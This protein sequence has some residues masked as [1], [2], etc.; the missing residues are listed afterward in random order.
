MASAEELHDQVARWLRARG[1]RYT[2]GRRQLVAALAGLGRPATIGEVLAADPDLPQSSAYRNL[3]TLEE[4][5]VV[6]RVSGADERARFEL[7]EALTGHHHHLVCTSCGEVTDVTIPAGVE[8]LLDRA[9]AA[10][11]EGTRFRVD[12]HRFDLVG[13]CAGCAPGAT[14]AGEG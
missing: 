7:T 14:G 3:A 1:Q 2:G 10:I 11:E 5:A 9:V 8:A 4:A 12:Q 13:T 6:H